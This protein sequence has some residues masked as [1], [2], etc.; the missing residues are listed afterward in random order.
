MKN[1]EE[2]YRNHVMWVEGEQNDTGFILRRIGYRGVNGADVL[3]PMM[4]SSSKHYSSVDAAKADN[5]QKIQEVIDGQ[6]D[7]QSVT[8][9]RAK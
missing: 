2:L 7:G 6:I 1:F 4:Q 8:F 9:P 5:F 3:I